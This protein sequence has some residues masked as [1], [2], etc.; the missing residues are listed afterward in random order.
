LEGKITKINLIKIVNINEIIYD[1]K[2]KYAVVI[3][4]NPRKPW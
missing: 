2:F 1:F 3:A 4:K